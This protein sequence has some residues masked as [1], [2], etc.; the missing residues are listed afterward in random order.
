MTNTECAIESHPLLPLLTILTEMSL[1][2]KMD[3]L[4]FKK[5]SYELAK[6]STLQ[7]ASFC[8]ENQTLVDLVIKAVIKRILKHLTQIFQSLVIA[9]EAFKILATANEPF[10]KTRRRLPPSAED[11]LS[12]WLIKHSAHPYMTDSEI[13]DFCNKYE[14]IEMDQV[15]I[16]LTNGRRKMSEGVRK[17]SK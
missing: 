16:F 14:G 1:S 8:D 2:E 17:R 7:E 13:S 9:E 12:N 6:V 11:E 15:R 10:K 5:L 3:P 4:N